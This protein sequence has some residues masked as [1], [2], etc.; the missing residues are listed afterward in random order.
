MSL[1]LGFESVCL[2][3]GAI[4]PLMKYSPV[5]RDGVTLYNLMVKEN[6]WDK[7][8]P[9]SGFVPALNQGIYVLTESIG[10]KVIVF[11]HFLIFLLL[12]FSSVALKNSSIS[13][14]GPTK[15]IWQKNS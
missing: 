1:L 14:C 2:L 12:H 9:N 3:L 5:Q 11:I 6:L 15:G 8:D 4:L 13:C 10:S 7:A